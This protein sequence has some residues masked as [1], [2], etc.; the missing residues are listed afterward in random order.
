[1]KG[2]NELHNKKTVKP[3]GDEGRMGLRSINARKSTLFGE[4]KRKKER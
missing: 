4:E 2:K 1:M 3:I